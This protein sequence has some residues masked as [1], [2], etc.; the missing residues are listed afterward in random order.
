MFNFLLGVLLHPMRSTVLVMTDIK[1][2]TG[3]MIRREQILEE[4]S[5]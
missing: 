4:E 5:P 1:A 3:K 2:T